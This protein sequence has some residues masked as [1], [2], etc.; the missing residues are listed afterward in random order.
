MQSGLAFAV[1]GIPVRVLPTFFLVSI[2]LGLGYGDALLVGLWVTVVFA[3]I[4][5][6][7]L[8][9]AAAYRW[10]GSDA[11]IV[12][13][14]FG[15]LTLGRSLSLG[16]DLVVSLAGP[17]ASLLVGVPLLGLAA[18]GTVTGQ[19]GEAVL[20]MAIW[21]NVGWA[22]INLLPIL[23]LDGGQALVSLL[24]M[25]TK[26]DATRLVNAVSVVVAGV[27]V[28]L[29]VQAGLLYAAVLAG[30]FLLINVHALS[31]RQPWRPARPARSARTDP[32]DRAPAGRHLADPRPVTSP[33]PV[34]PP[35]PVAPPAEPAGRGSGAETS[36]PSAAPVS[37]PPIV[38]RR[39]LDDEVASA[40]KAV[41]ANEPELALIAIARVRAH[42]LTAEQTVRADELEAWAWMQRG[43]LPS[44][45]P[46]IE[47]VPVGDPARALLE[48][49]RAGLAGQGWE[50]ARRL[51]DPHGEGAAL[52]ARFLSTMLPADGQG[53]PAE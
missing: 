4:L 40:I 15:G 25:I 21:V 20:T 6:H 44:A 7:E 33:A 22:L 12:L 24:S 35:V 48:A 18:S 47:A 10:F 2:L 50:E 41:V 11:A 34:A 16:R 8:G 13:H 17:A 1:A 29:A 46:F 27:A 39:S 23:P 52:S 19:T 9:H 30:L 3:S 37:R 49:G 36:P 45:A 53:E 38:G 31:Q 43:D 5:I 14:S 28:Y 42:G 26:R 51:A 32:G